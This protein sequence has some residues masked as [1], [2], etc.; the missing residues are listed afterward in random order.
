MSKINNLQPKTVDNSFLPI[1]ANA[2]KS[3]N[4]NPTSKQAK[5][6]INQ[7]ATRF[8]EMQKVQPQQQDDLKQPVIIDYSKDFGGKT[9]ISQRDLRKVYYQ[10]LADRA[11]LSE[12][13]KREFV[14]EMLKSSNQSFTDPDKTNYEPREISAD[15]KAKKTISI[16]VN[17][18][19]VSALQAYQN[20]DIE[21]DRQADQKADELIA[22]HTD[23]ST[24]FASDED[25]TWT[26]GIRNYPF[27]EESLGKD[28]AGESP[29]VTK[30]VLEK[31][32]GNDASQVAVAYA[33]SLDDNKLAELAGT[34][35][36]KSLLQTIQNK[37]SDS[38]TLERVNKAIQNPIL[39]SNPRLPDSFP[40]RYDADKVEELYGED[41]YNEN[42]VW[43]NI[44]AEGEGNFDTSGDLGDGGGL[45][46]GILQWTQN[47]GRLGELMQRYKNVAEKD[48]K[49]E[50]FYNNFGGKENAE[51]LL[52]QLNENP[53]SVSSASIKDYFHNAGR[54][55]SFQKAQIELARRDAP[56]TLNQVMTSHPYLKDN[57]VSKQSLAVSI[58]A[59]NIGPALTDK[60]HDK[61][62]SNLYADLV[63]KNPSL[64]VSNATP[65]QM[66]EITVKN[67]SENDYNKEF[68]KVA[69]NI[70]YSEKNAR[71]RTGTQN[72]MQRA[73]DA[74][75]PNEKYTRK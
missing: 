40:Q 15:F 49:L 72:R 1:G 19:T 36:G 7:L 42:D 10:K 51:N 69:P 48:G 39:L 38:P 31:L 55:E 14:A 58:I 73:L 9:K 44:I 30:K 35:T 28:L 5:A 53:R 33:K 24:W 13:S 32:S 8:A 27:D 22:K 61:T 11:N 18:D 20:K 74:F 67:V 54:S 52:K 66:K 23:K 64:A 45:S 62:I 34:K 4:L 21:T 43:A 6:A 57:S 2:S 65:A 46:V 56:N 60:I 63:K 59:S 17:D 29:L 50:E 26:D 68:V 16:R 70:L 12:T 25:G 37:T 75:Q 41:T 47:T 71:F 3:N